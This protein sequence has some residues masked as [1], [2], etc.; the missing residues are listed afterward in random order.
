VRYDQA[1]PSALSVLGKKKVTHPDLPPHE[2]RPCSP[3]VKARRQLG[4]IL[5]GASAGLVVAVAI[6]GWF[7]WPLYAVSSASA[8]YEAAA[9]AKDWT[10]ALAAAE[11]WVSLRPDSPDAWLNVAEASRQLGRFSLTAEALGRLPDS[12]P[13]ALTS[14]ALRG[15]LLLSE[16]RQPSAAIETWQRMLRTAPAADLPHKRLIYVYAM[17]LQRTKLRDQI[18]LAIELECDHPEMY[19]Y[20][21]LLPSLQFSDG[22]IKCADWLQGEPEN[23]ELR[24]AVAVHAARTAPTAT[25]TLF[26]TRT[27]MP[28]DRSLIRQCRDDYPG[29]PEVLAVFIDQALYEGDVS[30]VESMLGQVEPSADED[31]RFWRYRGW[32]AL[33]RRRTEE[34]AELCRQALER[35]PLDWRARHL[36][37]DAERLLGQG[38]AAQRNSEVAARGKALE[39]ELLEMPATDAVD[40]ARL[41][42]IGRLARDCGDELVAEGLTRRLGRLEGND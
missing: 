20:L 29:H 39:R 2:A 21:M 4:L 37:A 30:A 8:A 36:L 42:E 22:L 26:E 15:D 31:S 18:R 40:A 38:E 6:A 12:D 35:H 24:V 25:Q 10:A 1:D 5:G 33:M 41:R 32:A 28:G 19:V 14:L 16:L 9:Q 27:V 17:T 34:A 23:R 11:R 13:R 7:I 3:P